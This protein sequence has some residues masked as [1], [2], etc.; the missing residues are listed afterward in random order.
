MVSGISAGPGPRG[1]RSLRG[2][3]PA[4]PAPPTRVRNR[5]FRSQAPHP[6]TPPRR[7]RTIK[8]TS[9]YKL[10]SCAPLPRWPKNAVHSFTTPHVRCYSANSLFGCDGDYPHGRST[11]YGVAAGECVDHRRVRPRVSPL[12]RVPDS[13]PVRSLAL[14]LG[15]ALR[16][17][18]GPGRPALP[19]RHHRL[20][21]GAGAADPV[22]DRLA[23]KRP[24]T[25]LVRSLLRVHHGRRRA[26]PVSRRGRSGR[27]PRHGTGARARGRGAP[28]SAGL[29]IDRL[30]RPPLGAFQSVA[31]EG[32][33]NS[34]RPGKSERRQ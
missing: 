3:R 22:P 16:L 4:W 13:A 19:D 20:S 31:V 23:P 29:I 27:H 28:R 34:S 11:R 1:N 10:P 6:P 15:S 25:V 21:R 26:R 8:R 32:T 12:F 2:W 17:G 33:R 30:P 14:H 5:Y 9:S 7:H 24:G 18:P